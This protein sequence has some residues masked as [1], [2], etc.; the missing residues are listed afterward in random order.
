SR[1]ASGTAPCNPMLRR[2][3]P[4]TL[5]P[6][7]TAAEDTFGEAE[8]PPGL[9]VPGVALQDRAPCPPGEAH[10]QDRPGAQLL[11]VAHDLLDV[12]GPMEE[13][14]DAVLEDLGDLATR[15]R[16]DRHAGGSVLEHLERREV[17]ERQ[18][19]V[20]CQADVHPCQ[21][22]RHV[23]MSDLAGD[24]DAVRGA[25]PP[26]VVLHQASQ[27]AV[28]HHQQSTGLGLLAWLPERLEKDLH[29]VPLLEAAA[30]PDGALVS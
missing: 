1:V 9:T 15:A 14:V 20:G 3:A 11:D 24:R 22:A 6:L 12:P 19:R 29:T 25:V 10:P 30:A 17:E 18:R 26:A 8:Q 21:V 5:A 7:C 4:G 2:A 28:A 27:R 13:P 16:H 23:G